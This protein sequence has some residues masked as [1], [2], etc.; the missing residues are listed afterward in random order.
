M[1][2]ISV[3]QLFHRSRM[4]LTAVRGMMKTREPVA[5]TDRD[6]T[7]FLAPMGQRGNND[8]DHSG[9]SVPGHT[10]TRARR[11]GRGKTTVL[12]L[13]F[14]LHLF[15]MNLIHALAFLLLP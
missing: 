4:Y 2:F 11:S 15:F 3:M 6:Q 9:P 1:P 8:S 13:N 7:P 12:Y 10:A 14:Y 5:A